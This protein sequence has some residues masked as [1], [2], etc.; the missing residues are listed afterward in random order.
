[1]PG[2]MPELDAV[3]RDP[4]V[5]ESHGPLSDFYARWVKAPA[6]G[7]AEA[8]RQAQLAF[9]RGPAVSSHTGSDRGVKI[10]EGSTPAPHDAGYSYPY[11]WAP[12]VLIG[13]YK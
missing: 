3:A 6:D 1:M 10:A 4:A 12:F 9:L 11:C 5:P 13:N 2:V 7:K 8:L